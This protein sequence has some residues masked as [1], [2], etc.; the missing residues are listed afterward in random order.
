MGI[1]IK[2]NDKINLFFPNKYKYSSIVMFIF[3]CIIFCSL[4]RKNLT[5]RFN[6]PKSF[7]LTNGNILIIHQ[8]GIDVYDSTLKNLK[9]SVK[10]FGTNEK[11]SSAET[12]SKVSISRFD[13]SDTDN[14]IIVCLIIKKIYILNSD[15]GLLYEEESSSII[16]KFTGSYYDLTLINRD[17]NAYNYIVGFINDSSKVCLYFFE[18]HKINN[19]N[20]LKR[21]MDPFGLTKSNQNYNIKNKGIAC[22]IMLYDSQDIL[23]CFFNS[24]IYP[25]EMAT[26]FININDYSFIDL[27]NKYFEMDDVKSIKSVITSDK[28]T[29]LVCMNFAQGNVI[30]F[31]YTIDNNSFSQRKDYGVS[32]KVEHSSIS[33]EYFGETNQFI[34]SCTNDSGW[35]TSQTFDDNLC[36]IGK[37]NSI[38]KGYNVYGASMIYSKAL[39]NYYVISDMNSDKDCTFVSIYGEVAP[40]IIEETEELTTII[41]TILTTIPT[42]I[43]TT[44]PTTILTTIPTTI[45]TTIPTT[46]LTTIP[47]TILTTIPTNTLTTIPT[48]LPTLTTILTTIIEKIPY[49]CKIEKCLI[50]D[51]ESSSKDLCKECNTE[52]KYYPISPLINMGPLYQN[53]QYKDCYNDTT[54]PSN[55]FLNKNTRFY[56]P[57]YKTCATCQFGGDGNQHN[58]TTC[59]VDHTKEPEKENSTN[60]V[61]ICSYYYY[62][63]YGQYKCTTSPQCP[64]DNNLLIRENKKCIDKCSK[65]PKYK[66]QYNGECIEKCPDDTIQDNK[67]FLCKVKNIEICTQSSN[68]FDLYDFL[69]EGGVEKIAKNYANE[70]NY[71]NK[72][73]SLFKNEVYSIMLYKEK[74]CISELGLPMPEIDFGVCYEKVQNANTLQNKDLII[75]IIDKKSNKKSNPI[76]S[77]AFYNPE[78]GDKLN[79]EDICKEEVI[80]VK[81]NIKSILNE[82]VSNIDSIL[83]LAGQNINVFNKSSE[84]YTSI[85]YHFDSPCDKDVALRDRLL[86]YYPNITLCDA[87]CKNTGVNLTSMMAICECKFKE[88]TDEENEGDENIY[89]EVVNEVNKI[90]NQVNLAVLECYKD[91]FQYEFFISNTGG[92]I[93]LVLISIQIITLAVFYFSSLFLI[94]KYI[95]NVTD[96]YV[97]YL[98]RSPMVNNN[99]I[100]FTKKNNEQNND[101]ENNDNNPPKKTPS[102]KTDLYELYKN[103]NNKKSSTNINNK[104]KKNRTLKTQDENKNNKMLNSNHSKKQKTLLHKVKSYSF[105]NYNKLDKSE[106]DSKSNSY[107][108]INKSKD[109]LTFDDYLSTDLE[110]MNFHDVALVD[111]RLFFEYFCD[112]LKKKQLILQLFFVNSP[113]KPKT[114][115]ILLLILDIEICFVVNAMFINEDYVSEIFHSKSKENFFS[116]IPRAIDRIFYSIFASIVVSYFMGCL[117]VEES[118]IKGV[119]KREKNNITNLKL[120]INRIM[121]EVKIRYTIFIII[122]IIFSVFSW[123]YISCFNNIYPHMKLEWIKSSLLVIIL[124]HVLSVFV[125]LIE[126]LL[127]FISFEIKSERMYR[128]SLWLG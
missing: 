53:N 110:D 113:I 36:P 20:T 101:K 21:E 84:F 112:K 116:F 90:L 27:E 54:K 22:E 10:S 86:V 115:K 127:R 12:L 19:I 80:I 37:S 87:G 7:T 93:F 63:S 100:N 78:N 42:T 118:K 55:F 59:D 25:N 30:C 14:I 114:I 94:S 13:E 108:L 105:H 29:S 46:I 17:G 66:Y 24:D 121:K 44:I 32:C 85:C 120:Q 45:L 8:N 75:A 18:Y 67:E 125:I 2:L 62:Y 51:E 23:A 97:L 6:Y 73:I 76:T 33:F 34:F 57:C 4:I 102:T 64:D 119:F 38:V 128:A 70:F 107:T 31:N 124:I 103:N 123:F 15:G 5:I 1:K 96:N 50:C 47:T 117:F 58:C 43:L 65:D 72:H 28:K 77:Y 16:N 41:T 106:S 52:K 83:F 71:T 109:N 49:N 79:S 11:I 40:T 60:C 68:Q 74:N 88:M 9:N 91:L 122:T 3:K 81:E 69:K 89:K 92:I 61:A 104:N 95:Y 126:T 56:E 35:I 39:G 98:N 26:K 99:I 48:T 82:T 111:R